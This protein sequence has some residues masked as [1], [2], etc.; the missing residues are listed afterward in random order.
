MSKLILL[1]FEK[2]STLRGKNLLLR[3]ANSFLLQ[4]RLA[5]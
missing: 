2:G 1:S 5:V 4:K 3:G